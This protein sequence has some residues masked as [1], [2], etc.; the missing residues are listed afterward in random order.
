MSIPAYGM[1]DAE[2]LVEKEIRAAWPEAEVQVV[3][4]GRA[5][6]PR[7]VEEFEVAYRIVATVRSVAPSRDAAKRSAFRSGRSRLENTRYGR[8]AWSC[9]GTTPA[10][11]AP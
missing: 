5:G 1:A 2:H 9:T 7:I 3:E 8:T 4:I 10:T 11:G 6:E